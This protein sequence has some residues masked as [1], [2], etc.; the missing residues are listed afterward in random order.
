[1]SEQAIVI[2]AGMVGVSVAW[3]L[4][5][6]G[7]QVTLID[8]KQPGEETSY[9][10]AGLIQRE[11]VFPH[12]FPRDVKEIFKVI[13]N[14]NLDIRYR[15]A[16]LW[17]FKNP[18]MQ[19]WYYSDPK[20]FKTVVAEWSTLIEHCT[21]THDEMMQA[22]HAEHLV[23]KTGWLQLHRTTETYAKAI[24]EAEA[25]RAYGVQSR[26]VNMQEVHEMEPDLN[27]SLFVGGIH[28]QNTWKVTNPSALV[29]AYAE[30]FV[31][32]GGEFKQCQMYNMQQE[33]GEWQVNTDQGRL[34][35]KH[36]VVATGP[37]SADVLK[38]LGYDYPLFPM[39]G[40]H[41][42]YH[43]AEGKQLNHSVL[44]YDCGYVIGP[45]A[46]GI[47]I[48]TGA[49]FTFQNAPADERQLDDVEKKARE[50]LPLT[51][52]VE[53]KA[54]IGHRPCMPDMKPV[55]GP[56]HKHGNLWFAFGH[57]HQGFTLGPATGKLLA[58]MMLGQA[59]YVNPQPFAANRFE[60]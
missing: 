10:N 39:R 31:T 17:H 6:Q 34:S 24:A 11:A 40:Y 3:H 60:K 28:W 58:Q 55:I 8:R 15:P 12:A 18:L 41:K 5:Q 14:H 52:A 26:L 19:Y 43:I 33:N 49:E 32:A 9:G 54:W 51:T 53:D 2:G 21:E 4:Q 36:L 37:W 38:G 45:K 1:M 48:T 44:D 7:M 35:A 56:A 13:P 29:K 23:R 50:Y 42:H 27:P 57:A 30:N 59:T 16:A 25:A 20:R 22:A 47:R 46:A